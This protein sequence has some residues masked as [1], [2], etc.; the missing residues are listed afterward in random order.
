LQYDDIAFLH[1]LLTVA[2][3]AVAILG[4]LVYKSSKAA[5]VKSIK[6]YDRLKKCGLYTK[7]ISNE[8][9]LLKKQHL[10]SG[11]WIMSTLLAS[12][13]IIIGVLVFFIGTHQTQMIGFDPH[14]ILGVSPDATVNQIKKAYRYF[15]EL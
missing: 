9:V 1:F 11:F 3:V 5:S 6:N 10:T 4:Y 7:Q 13:I 15:F 2:I 14:E 8:A 12:F